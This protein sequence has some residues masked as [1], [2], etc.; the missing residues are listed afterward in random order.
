[1]VSPGGEQMKKQ[2]EVGDKVAY[3]GQFLRDTG[4]QA[5]ESGHMRGTVIEVMGSPDW[6][7]CVVAWKNGRQARTSRVL[8][9]N[10]ARVGT[11]AMSVN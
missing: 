7:L 9:K 6:R 1:M 2:I 8:D 4:Q 10:L 5:G 11:P 3:S